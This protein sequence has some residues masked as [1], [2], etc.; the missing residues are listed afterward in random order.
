MTYLCSACALG[1]GAVALLLSSLWSGG[2]ALAAVE[3]GGVVQLPPTRVE[4]LII[5]HPQ[6]ALTLRGSDRPGLAISFRKQA[7]S[8][9]MLEVLQVQVDVID[10]VV[11]VRSGVETRGELRGLPQPDATIDLVIDAP[12][13]AQLLA[14]T[15]SGALTV[16]GFHN[17]VDVGSQTGAIRVSNV[18]GAVRTHSG[19]GDQWLRAIS[20]SVDARGLIGELR[21]YAVAGASLNAQLV[22]GLIAARDVRSQ[23]LRMHVVTGTIELLGALP[24][25]ARYDLQVEQG[26]IQVSLPPRARFQLDAS[27]PQLQVRYPLDPGSVSAPGLLRGSAGGGGAALR[28]RSA[29]GRVGLSPYA[30]P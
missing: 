24:P 6:G 1:R 25:E 3:E 20:G 2:P 29:T 11:R 14:S 12:R 9:A 16:S 10:G 22:S 15:F 18:S 30:T 19:R 23:L 21:F 5:D 27:A 13:G 26:D 17:D 7:E 28:L 8:E 4:R